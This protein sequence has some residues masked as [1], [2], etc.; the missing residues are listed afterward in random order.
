MV[1]QIVSQLFGSVS[2]D[3]LVFY[4]P[5]ILSLRLQ[6]E[7]MWVNMNFETTDITSARKSHPSTNNFGDTFAFNLIKQIVIHFSF[8]FLTQNVL[9]YP[10]KT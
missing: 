1:R 7:R 4:F 5:I 9:L 3:N 8:I 10:W 2:G 6:R